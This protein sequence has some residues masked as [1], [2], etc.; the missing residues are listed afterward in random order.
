MV[1]TTFI[2]NSS[3]Y[4]KYA[5][6]SQK[7]WSMN[8][9]MYCSHDDIHQTSRIGYRDSISTWTWLFKIG[10]SF[11]NTLKIILTTILLIICVWT[12]KQA[13]MRK[14]AENGEV[15]MLLVYCTLSF[16]VNRYPRYW[17]P[18][19]AKSIVLSRL[20]TCFCR[21]KACKLDL[22]VMFLAG[23]SHCFKGKRCFFLS[24]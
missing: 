16:N 20:L 7:I 4:L 19:R 23:S 9:V 22:K 5:S 6:N 21:A 2:Q 24:N 15:R 8:L 3:K 17:C 10:C 11:I 1:C 13:S 12:N 14:Y 18:L